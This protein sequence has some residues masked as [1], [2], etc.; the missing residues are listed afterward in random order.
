MKALIFSDLHAHNFEEFSTTEDGV[1]A[2]LK[3]QLLALDYIVGDAEKYKV[4]CVIFAGDAFHLKNFADS[5][6][7]SLIAGRFAS[8]AA[9][10][11]F[12]MCPGN[13]DYKGW[14]RSP[15]LLDMFGNMVANI[16]LHDVVIRGWNIR[17][18][19]Y[20]RNIEETNAQ[21]AS[22][23]KEKS[24]LGI[25]HNDIYGQQYG[26][27]IV[28][29]GLAAE[30]IGSK[31]DFSFVGHFHESK[32]IRKN[33]VSVGSP[34]MLSFGEEGQ[35]KGWW[36]F[37]S[38]RETVLNFIEDVQ[39]PKFITLDIS[40][41]A[42]EPRNYGRA[43]RDYFR[44]RVTGTEIPDWVAALKWKRISIVSDRGAKARTAITAEDS[45]ESAVK[46]YIQARNK[47]LDAER[48]YEMGVRYLP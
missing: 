33:V 20:N 12:I 17:L 21:V 43:Q 42:D 1:N 13:H 23:K 44:V 14:N 15:F 28:K 2:R 29:R 24:S 25:F 10:T 26:G 27:I 32:M 7:I 6:V 22:V 30:Q 38:D 19:P 41:N 11:N 31:F 40:G 37:D 36:I 4:D 34:T 47:G 18:F 5:Q 45:R 8:I 39:T 3:E 46:K 35:R 48:L 16:I 9:Q